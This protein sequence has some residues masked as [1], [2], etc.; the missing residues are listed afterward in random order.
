VRSA[1]RQ[2]YGYPR[3]T[4]GGR[5]PCVTREPAGSSD[6][7][8]P[9]DRSLYAMRLAERFWCCRVS[10][11]SEVGPA[12]AAVSHA[13]VR[14]RDGAGQRPPLSEPSRR[15]AG[16][17]AQRFRAS[18]AVP[19]IRLGRITTGGA[20]RLADSAGTSPLVDAARVRVWAE[21]AFPA[22]E[23]AAAGQHRHAAAHHGGAMK[24]A[25]VTPACRERGRPTTRR[26]R[27]RLEPLKKIERRPMCRSTRIAQRPS[28][29]IS[30][31]SK[32]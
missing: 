4:P 10:R 20:C 32:S 13:R 3:F 9:I 23:A 7:A 14:W 16:K 26:V 27:G 29:R 6:S 31:G 8:K 12:R 18:T 19:A 24:W 15:A 25:A 28:G 5:P 21:G 1:T 30:K 22:R 2:G 11:C 17:R